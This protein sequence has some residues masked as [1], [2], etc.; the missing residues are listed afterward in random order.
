MPDA[1]DQ[2]NIPD[3]DIRIDVKQHVGAVAVGGEFTGD[4]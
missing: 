3:R 2:P 4:L 1:P